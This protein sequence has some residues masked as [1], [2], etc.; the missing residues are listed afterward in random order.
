M[1]PEETLAWLKDAVREGDSEEAAEHY[2]NLQNWMKD[3]GYEPTMDWDEH[4][5]NIF[6]HV[7]G[8]WL[9]AEGH[10]V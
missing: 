2:M 3:E 1:D 6:L 5:L 8:L 9:K 4:T 10:D 7:T